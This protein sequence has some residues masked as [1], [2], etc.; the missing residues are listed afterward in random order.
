MLVEKFRSAGPVEEVFHGRRRPFG[1]TTGRSFMEA[2]ELR[3]D[4]AERKIGV[5]GVN[6]GDEG[7]QAVF[8]KAR[9]GFFE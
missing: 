6:A 5:G 8:R 2:F 9:R 4:L 7:H 1:T 3:S